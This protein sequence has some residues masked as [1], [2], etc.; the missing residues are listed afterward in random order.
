MDVVNRTREVACLMVTRG[1][2]I[3]LMSKDNGKYWTFPQEVIR[4]R[5]D[6]RRAEVPQEAIQRMLCEKFDIMS[7]EEGSYVENSEQHPEARK[8]HLSHRGD[9]TLYHI[10]TTDPA[11]LKDAEL[12]KNGAK[13]TWTNDPYSFNLNDCTRE[14][15]KSYGF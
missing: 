2:E 8:E 14:T 7:A 12:T 3:L 9:M 6:G 10:F 11:N 13:C 15:L 1:D 5:A 4:T